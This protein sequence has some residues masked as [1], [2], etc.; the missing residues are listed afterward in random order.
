MNENLPNILV[1]LVTPLSRFLVS[2]LACTEYVPFE[3]RVWKMH[4]FPRL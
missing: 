3:L 2:S 4:I 1:C